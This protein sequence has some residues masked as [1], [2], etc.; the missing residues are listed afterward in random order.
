MG[1]AAARHYPPWGN[2]LKPLDVAGPRR[3]EETH[4]EKSSETTVPAADTV[5]STRQI[6]DEA[7]GGLAEAAVFPL[8]SVGVP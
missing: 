8:V 7:R 5:L 2:S 3:V 4:K 6:N 1:V